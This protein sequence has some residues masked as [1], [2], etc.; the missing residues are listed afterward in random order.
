V[1]QA[2]PEFDEAVR[3]VHRV[4]GDVVARAQRLAD[5]GDR[6]ALRSLADELARHLLRGRS[7]IGGHAALR[8]SDRAALDAAFDRA[9]PVT[10]PT[11]PVDVLDAPFGTAS[12]RALLDALVGR[13]YAGGE[14]DRA[15][16]LE[17]AIAAGDIHRLR[18]IAVSPV[19]RVTRETLVAAFDALHA[20]D[21]L[22]HD[23][24]VR[25]FI[26][27][28]FLGYAVLGLSPTGT[29]TGGERTGPTA[30]C[31]PVVRSTLDELTWTL[32]VEQGAVLDELP[33]VIR[34]R[35]LR[36]VQWAVTSATDP[37]VADHLGAADL[38][39]AELAE[40]VTW[41]E[42]RSEQDRMRAFELRR[43]SDDSAALLPVLGIG[44]AAVLLRLVDEAAGGVAV[45]DRAAILAAVQA[46]GPE[47][48]RSLLNL[49][50]S[51]LVSA[52][53]GWNRAEVLKRVKHNA[54]AGIAA[55]GMLP[56]ADG[57]TVL[58][59]YLALRE[60]A[61]RGPKLGTNRRHT[62]AAA[63]DVALGHLAQVAGFADAARLE[64]DCEAR[65][66]EAS[67]SAW[68]VGDYALAVRVNGSEPSIVVDKAGR[69][70]KSVPA[71][72]RSAPEYQAA[73]ESQE[74]LRDQARRMRAGLVERLVATAGRLEPDELERLLSL[75]AGAAM[76]PELLW[77]DG[78][79]RIGLLSD[80][81]SSEGL[82]AVHP[83][84]LFD[85]GLLSHW[86][87]EVVRR[88][89][90]QP[91]KQVFRELYLLTPAERDAGAVSNRFA[92]HLLHGGRAG[93]LL[94]GRGWLHH[95]EYDDYQA[96]RRVGAL[97]ASVGAD[98]S[99]FPGHSEMVLRDVRFLA[100]RVAV[101]LA[102]VPPVDLSEVMRDLDLVV[103]VA[104]TEPVTDT[105]SPRAASR[106]ALLAALIEDLGLDRVRVDGVVAV[107]T[108]SRATYRVHLNS[109]S[110]HVEPAGYL[111]IVP[112]GFGERAHQRL[113][114]PFADEDRM[115][116]V[117]LSK[118]LLLAEDEKITDRS[119]VEQIESNTRR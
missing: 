99:G 91:V 105:G 4:Y 43:P 15:P 89:L 30:A 32:A 104:G 38:T 74:R 17:A 90:R 9:F 39:A 59:R 103:S 73:R 111:C 34:P 53:L 52:A 25:A 27:D 60:V 112:A 57:E 82:T 47:H 98:V 55:F 94:S 81:D 100:G 28:R 26:D 67:V 22:D 101:P 6:P 92:G 106:A 93:A 16:L 50:P 23:T 83:Y 72:V 108:G 8:P 21:A 7:R 3:A 113:F 96:T 77:L 110:I 80:V 20:A 116:T 12:R 19:G 117:I 29:G 24:V 18:L 69:E 56:L 41:L 48:T 62:H 86:Q 5:A 51:E 66:A 63:V 54:L 61:R 46:A 102:E 71:A 115:T 33:R 14:P 70:L 31:L 65:V 49:V 78:S 37:H 42:P 64:W 109:G 88:R 107:V 75:P 40:L 2:S 79:D 114:L 11:D 35:G 58:D 119:I 13:R 76:L 95:R 10:D 36:F 68:R 87:A 97:V 45:R 1:T 85:R 44:P 118:V 84:L